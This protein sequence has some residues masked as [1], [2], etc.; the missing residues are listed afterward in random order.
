MVCPLFYP[1][2]LIFFKIGELERKARGKIHLDTDNIECLSVK[3]LA[4]GI[5]PHKHCY[6][7][8]YHIN[9]DPSGN[10]LPCLFFQNYHIGNIQETDINKLWGNAKHMDF[11]RSEENGKI[12][13]CQ[14]CICGVQRNPGISRSLYNIINDYVG[15]FNRKYLK[16]K[17]D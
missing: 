6:M 2:L 9:V 11:I 8:R 16:N 3:D 17:N 1:I 15:K 14:Q 13:V 10:V 4:T 7:V 5:F 12:K